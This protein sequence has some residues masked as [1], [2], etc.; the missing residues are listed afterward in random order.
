[1]TILDLS[2]VNVALPSI[3]E[4]LGGGSTEIQLIVSGFVLAFGLLLVPMGR[5]GDQVSPK[6]LFLIGLVLYAA[7]SALCALAPTPE[8]LIVGRIAQGVAAGIQMPQVMG[9]L[10]RVFTGRERGMAFGLLGA[11]IGLGTALGPVIGGLFVQLGDGH[12]GWRGI[13]WMNVPLA[14]VIAAIVVWA[15]PDLRPQQ[16]GRISL[17]P[18]GVALF[19]IAV[20]ALM[21][22]FLF[23]TGEPT[24]DPRRWWSL[25]V[26][27]PALAGFVAWEARYQARGNAPLVPP[28][29]LRIPS[30]R[31]GSLLM[32]AYFAGMPAIFLT[33]T[34]YLQT[35]LGIG[36]LAA[37]A[38]TMGFALASAAS[39][40]I[41]GRLVGRIGRP[42]VVTGLVLVM[43]SVAGLGLVAAFAPAGAVTWLMAGVM[44]LGGLGGGI[45]ISPNQTLTLADIPPHEGGLA[46]SVGQLVQRIGTA[47]G[48]AVTLSLFYATVFGESG[49]EAQPVVYRDAYL[50]GLLAVGACLA[51]ALVFALMDLRSR[52]RA[53]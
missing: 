31:N 28:G 23:T 14:L 40:V 52:R 42:L 41:G 4:V 30:F 13:F 15:L 12:D 36:A 8:A 11:T 32:T 34:L 6:R 19:A 33:T 53:R 46:G 50:H 20:L 22:P 10:Q 9:T 2:K 45:V 49:G 3:R 51:L 17:D 39:S 44:T 47:V 48:T 5:L 35:G 7:T 1:M 16:R 29:L 24:D 18:V 25:A 43:A 38:T 27:V 26:F 21:V 37:G